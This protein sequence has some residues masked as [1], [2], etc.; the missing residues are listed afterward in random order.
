AAME[1][2]LAKRG[3]LDRMRV[4]AELRNRDRAFFIEHS[5]EGQMATLMQQPDFPALLDWLEKDDIVKRFSKDHP[6][7]Y[8]QLRALREMALDPSCCS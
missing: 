4:P 1:P 3:E 2:A 5:I 6:Q 8:A 7:V